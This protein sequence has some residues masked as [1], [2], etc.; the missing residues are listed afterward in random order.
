MQIIEVQFTPWDQSYF[1]KPETEEGEILDL[2]GEDKVIVKT[3]LGTDLATVVFRGELAELPENVEEVKPIIRQATPEDELKVLKINKNKKELLEECRNSIKKL[4]LPMKLI[5]VH[6][7]FDENRI[8]FAFIADGRVDFR[9]LVKEL[10]HKYQKSIR[11]HQVGV[12]DEA[13][14]SGDIGS[15]GRPLCCRL[16]LNELG[17]VSTEMAKDQQV[18]HRGAERLSGSCGRLKCCLRYEQDTYEELAKKLPAIG[19][20]FKTKQGEG[21]VVGWHTLKGSVDVDL[22]TESEV[23]IIEVPLNKTS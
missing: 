20:K 9:E 15:C 8:T 19:S 5:D 10:A 2:Q 17:N 1:F 16:Y 12:R 4:Q 11:L 6:Q 22:G 21:I 18:A 3:Q 23:N 13:K 7:S 14:I